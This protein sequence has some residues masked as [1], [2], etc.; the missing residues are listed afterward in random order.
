MLR[1]KEQTRV[2]ITTPT[3]SFVTKYPQAVDFANKQLSIFWLPDEIKVEKDVHDIIVNMSESERHG[4]ITVLKLFTLYELYAGAEYWSTRVL[5][6]FPRPEIQ[7]MAAT[8]SM[9]ELAVHQPFYAKLNEA[10][11]LNTD[12]FYESY[13]DNPVLKERM[14]FIDNYVNSE[15]LDLSLA[16]F[17]LIEG[18]VLYSSFAFL[19]HFQS[20][21]KNKLLNVVRGINFSVRDEALHS[22]AGAWLFRQLKQEQGF[23][24]D[25]TSDGPLRL[26]VAE[27]AKKIYEH[28]CL[29]ID[30]IFEKGKIDGITPKQ[31]K[32]FVESRINLCLKNLG[33]DKMFD[34][35]YN[36]IGEYFYKGINN[37]IFNDFFT[38]IG[39]SYSRNWDEKSFQW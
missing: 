15:R 31:L 1:K 18:V 37:F 8:F 5:Q 28:E 16:V 20:Q 9:F 7:R 13:T 12:E 21:G 39:S 34:V 32:H 4:V 3:I 27:A 19:K 22:E 24:G 30:M 35:T 6:S 38:G 29:I 33:Y 14:E 36:P 11:G 25:V 26:E 23:V 10:L 2:Q 17:S